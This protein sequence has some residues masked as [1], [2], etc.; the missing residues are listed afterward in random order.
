MCHATVHLHLS[1]DEHWPL[2]GF[3]IGHPGSEACLCAS[4]L[5]TT[6]AYNQ[7]GTIFGTCATAA[8]AG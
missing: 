3:N 5:N 6:D 1:I 4:V 2:L 8:I 7:A